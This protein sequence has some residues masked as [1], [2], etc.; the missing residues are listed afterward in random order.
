M[1]IALRARPNVEEQEPLLEG[2]RHRLCLLPH[3]VYI[4][5]IAQHD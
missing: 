4:D 5:L 2:N 1:L 3:Q